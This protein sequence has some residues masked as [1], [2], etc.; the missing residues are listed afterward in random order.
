MGVE[1]TRTV[2]YARTRVDEEEIVRRK[3]SFTILPAR[4]VKGSK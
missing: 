4:S 2:S 3:E 1:G